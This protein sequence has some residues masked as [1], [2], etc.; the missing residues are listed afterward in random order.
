MSATGFKIIESL[1]SA[2]RLERKFAIRSYSVEHGYPSRRRSL[3]GDAKFE[4]QKNREAIQNWIEENRNASKDYELSE[5]EAIV[6]QENQQDQDKKALKRKNLIISLGSDGLQSLSKLLILINQT[7]TVEHLETRKNATNEK[8]F[9]VFCTLLVTT[10]DLLLFMK[11]IRHSGLGDVSL[12]RDK[13]ISVKDPWFPRHI[14]DLDF[15]THIM[16]KFEPE[17]DTDHPGFSDKVYRKRRLEIAEIAFNYRYGQQIPRVTYTEEEIKTWGIVYNE[18]VFK[19]LENECGYSPTNIP[20]LEDVSRFLKKRTGFTLRPAAG[21]LTARDFLASLAFRVFQTTQYIRHPSKPDHS[22]EPDCVHELLGH[23]PILADESFA[24]FSQQIGLASLGAS[25]EDLVKL[26]TLYWF[27]VEFGLCREN[28]EIRAYGAGL[29]SSFG[30]LEHSLS[31]KPEHREFEP[32]KTAVQPYQDLDYQEIYF[33]AESFDDAKE[34][35]KKYV[36]EHLPRRFEV[37]YDANTDRIHVIDS[38]EKLDNVI[39]KLSLQMQCAHSCATKLKM[40]LD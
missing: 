26:A 21:L 16:T 34:K 13:L 2:N 25:D 35:L 23:I 5:E 40:A 24:D 29:L 17:L 32:E 38:V 39:K 7:G 8:R 27:T 36:E 6:T 11:S 15:C 18:L 33:V 22:P 31:N 28:G 20:Q 19:I 10:S 37:Y 3:V 12:L 30:E 14:S 4:T 9:D 1:A